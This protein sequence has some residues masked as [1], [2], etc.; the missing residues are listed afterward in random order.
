MSGSQL[1]KDKPQLTGFEIL[2]KLG[3][4]G[5]ARVYLARQ[6][7]QDRL[8]AIKCL[9]PDRL[10][11]DSLLRLSLEAT[12]LARIS[13]SGIVTIH[14]VIAD[15]SG[16]F[17]VMEYLSGGTLRERLER[18]LDLGQALEITISLARALDYAHEQGI[19]HRD[20]KPGNILFRDD[21]TPVITDFGIVYYLDTRQSQRL[22]QAGTFLGTPTYLSPEQIRGEPGSCQSD[23]YA[24]GIVM[25]EMLTGK[26]PFCGDTIQSVIYGHL[27][28]SPAPLPAYL[29]PLQPILDQLL[30]KQQAD[31]FASGRALI[32][33]LKS[34]LQANPSLLKEAARHPALS[35]PEQLKALGL[36]GSDD[37][38][39][40][41]IPV[42]SS[43]PAMRKWM[44]AMLAVALVTV[45]GLLA[46]RSFDL[47]F[48]ATVNNTPSDTATDE[49]AFRSELTLA[50]LP[51][52][53]MSANRDQGYFAD[54]LAEELLNLL[55]GVDGLSVTARTSAFTMRDRELTVSEIGQRLGVAHVLQGSV[56]KSG[57]RLRIS[58]QLIDTSSGFY[59]WSQ[60]YDR[61][62]ED[63]FEIQDEIAQS[64]AQ[65]LRVR[66]TASVIGTNNLEAYD[67][68][69]KAINL[70]DS[71]QPEKLMQA[72]QL[73]DDALQL[74]PD[75]APALAASGELW[76]HLSNRPSAYGDI[77]VDE[78]DA[79]AVRDLEKALSL[80]PN[81]AEAHAAM[82]LLAILSGDTVNAGSSLAR[83]LELNPSLA[84]ASNWQAGML[85][86]HGM[87]NEALRVR[88][89]FAL[90]DPLFPVNRSNLAIA[91]R[92]AG[93]YAAAERTSSRL[94]TEFP[95]N[96]LGWMSMLVVLTD[97]GRLA[98][99]VAAS[100]QALALDP[101]RFLNRL[102][103]ERLYFKL[104]EFEQSAAMSVGYY[105]ARA[106][107]GSGQIEE[108]RQL[109]RQ[110]MDQPPD[111]LAALIGLIEFLALAGLHQ[112]VLDLVAA[113]WGDAATLDSQMPKTS[114]I[115]DALA[116][117][118]IAQRGLGLEDELADTLAIWRMS[119]EM[120]QANGNGSTPFHF[121][122]ARY[123]ALAGQRE[124]A[125]SDLTEAIGRGY[126]NPL[127]GS[128]PAF[129]DLHDDPEF[130]ELVER[131]VDQINAE[132]AQLNLAPFKPR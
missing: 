10:D 13:Y 16:L 83:A 24:L 2:D 132:R 96:H 104:A 22:T 118:A 4:G 14:D 126:R 3:E 32:E 6:I 97:Q 23:L 31:R 101:D 62:L 25:Y 29:A 99:A 7:S 80:N 38:A 28:Q 116:P 19:I 121:A 128:D 9:R 69:L 79:A 55:A 127:L 40:L 1:I 41:V 51:F 105:Q 67:L 129:A 95:D 65:A 53:D 122:Q 119:L 63:V 86:A 45:I 98:D 26:A 52:T 27:S 70:I 76:L 43:L 37:Q 107:L 17:M 47:V 11:D 78:A 82:G 88:T 115:G 87:A 123:H 64:I 35:V 39:T 74:D 58:A 113:L 103:S 61:V 89:R 21:G 77:P 36:T 81:L 93:Q 15:D 131:V 90:L 48:E 20:L 18:P 46:Y 50:V 12:T 117:L 108:A 85:Q 59:L 54:G 60:A 130:I 72:R 42:R 102:Y 44:P 94:Q 110:Q 5:A 57:H 111:N 56:R 73:L 106:L 124:P 120:M 91:Q 100:G 66:L 71:R 30:A 68:Y 112:D 33:S 114:M 75:Y 8:V 92:L 34:I 49:I 109:A 84:G 125:L